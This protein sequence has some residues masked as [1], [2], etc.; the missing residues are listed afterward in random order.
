MQAS[1]LN[2]KKI[3]I[4]TGEVNSGKSSAAEEMICRF[5]ACGM[6]A[7]G[8]LCHG[9]FFGSVKSGFTGIDIST[10][11]EYHLASGTYS[12]KFSLKQ[13][14]FYFDE[15]AFRYLNWL[16]IKQM[17]ADVILIDEAGPLELN[18]QG[19]YSALKTCLTEF[20]GILMIT[21]RIS[22]VNDLTA[23]FN[24]K[25]ENYMVLEIKPEQQKTSARIL[26]NF[27]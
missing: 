18:R 3:I 2:G 7:G 24:M 11:K 13:G 27:K 19:F 17:D 20:K 1:W 9:I 26:E 10:G 5:E 22:L 6:K 25:R 16:I 8:I 15:K 4:I 14:R 21:T 12:E 23:A